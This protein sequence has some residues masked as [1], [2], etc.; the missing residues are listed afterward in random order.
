MAREIIKIGLA[1]VDG[2]CLLLVRKRGSDFYILPGGKPEPGESDIEAL[3]REV[4]E[5]LG[6][7]IESEN[8]VFLGSFSDQAAGQADVRVTVKL[9]AGSLIGN[10]SPK[11]E[12]DKLVWLSPQ[13]RQA[14]NLA[15]SLRNSILPFLSLESRVV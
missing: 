11:S 6:C 8:L 2:N 5:E 4:D 14:P 3:S 9:Y 1:V 10:P 12:I 15:P 7:R 13:E